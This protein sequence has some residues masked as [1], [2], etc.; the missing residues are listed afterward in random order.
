MSFL[1]QRIRAREGGVRV[2]NHPR[3][4]IRTL[5]ACDD[6]R[7]DDGRKGASM[8]AK[9][10]DPSIRPPLP[11]S[12]VRRVGI[13]KT[14]IEIDNWEFGPEQARMPSVRSVDLSILDLVL[15][16]HVRDAGVAAVPGA[17]G[18]HKYHNAP[19][20]YLHFCH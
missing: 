2:S 7:V 4:G 5:A 1:R 16:Q 15:P 6:F 17:E 14:Q 18:S 9:Q 3:L 8:H 12:R 10:S 11:S 19:N 20:G 13:S